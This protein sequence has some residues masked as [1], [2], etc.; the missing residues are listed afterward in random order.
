M[1]RASKTKKGAEWCRALPDHSFYVVRPT[2]GDVA[3]LLKA[4]A[5]GPYVNWPERAES[6]AY[7]K[8]YPFAHLSFGFERSCYN[9]RTARSGSLE[10]AY[11][12]NMPVVLSK[13]VYR[14]RALMEGPV[15]RVGCNLVS[16]S[17]ALRVAKLLSSGR[18]GSVRFL[19]GS[20]V[21][22]DG[23]VI[24]DVAGHNVTVPNP[25]SLIKWA[26]GAAAVREATRNAKPSS[27]GS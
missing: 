18:R 24:A 12:D 2:K 4:G 25:M 1:I 5:I 15:M 3:A 23:E 7:L 16:R 17:Q 21:V 19:N 11:R 14:W 26:V 13:G 22:R 20:C 10:R 9:H 6:R 8:V 27:H